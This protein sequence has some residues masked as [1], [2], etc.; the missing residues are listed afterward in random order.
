MA[1]KQDLSL[2]DGTVESNRKLV[3]EY[4]FL[5]PKDNYTGRVPNNYDYSYTKLD[6]MPAGWR[7]KFGLS[8]CSSI[9]KTLEK[10]N[11]LKGFAIE[12]IK[13]KFGALQVYTY[14]GTRVIENLVLPNYSKISE[15]VCCV[16]GERATKIAV[17]WI[18]P[19]CDKCANSERPNSYVDI[20]YYYGEENG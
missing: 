2:L 8:M 7:K 13:E 3:E 14:G 15:R 17:P 9:K 12:S 10:Q 20:D 6:E 1:T 16:C 18:V 19:L 4:P 5:L 11:A